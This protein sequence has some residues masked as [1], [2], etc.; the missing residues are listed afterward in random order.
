VV[1]KF[2]ELLRRLSDNPMVRL[3][4]AIAAAMVHGA[5]KG[6]ELLDT[7]KSSAIEFVVLNAYHPVAV[8][9]FFA[10]SHRPKHRT[11]SRRISP[12]LAWGQSAAAIPT[13]VL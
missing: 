6:L 13:E 4:H 1:A 3:N 12:S 7:L 2:N 11:S 5:T 10:I 8:A 9:L